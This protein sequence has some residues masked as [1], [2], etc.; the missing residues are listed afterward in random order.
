MVKRRN[1]KELMTDIHIRLTKEEKEKI[2]R[3]QEGT[4]YPNISSFT[5]SKL[6]QD[7]IVVNNSFPDIAKTA[8]KIY[9]LLEGNDFPAKQ[10]VMTNL[11]HLLI[12]AT[13]K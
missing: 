4:P 2:K 8:Y 5:K 1:T 6:L 13:E 11:S 12:K 3:L 10:E 7:N 9:C